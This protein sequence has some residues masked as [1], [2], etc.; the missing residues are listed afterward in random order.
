[1]FA[2]II[3]VDIGQFRGF[4]HLLDA[5]HKDRHRLVFPVPDVPKFGSFI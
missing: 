3:D 5:I 4:S 1:M 2:L